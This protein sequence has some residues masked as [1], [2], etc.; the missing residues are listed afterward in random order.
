MATPLAFAP[1]P[2]I[3]V[4]LDLAQGYHN[5]IDS[6]MHITNPA[7]ATRKE[8]MEQKVEEAAKNPKPE[9]VRVK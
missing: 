7:K 9:P 1:P 2:L 8:K 4:L 6:E 5:A 3:P